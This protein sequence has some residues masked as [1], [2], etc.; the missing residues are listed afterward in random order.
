M[1][2]VKIYANLN[3]NLGLSYAFSLGWDCDDN[4]R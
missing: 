2:E 3:V 4:S 1:W